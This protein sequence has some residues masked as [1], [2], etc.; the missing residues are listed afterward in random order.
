MRNISW[1]AFVMR[2]ALMAALTIY[3]YLQN[4]CLNNTTCIITTFNVTLKNFL[5]KTSKFVSSAFDPLAPVICNKHEVQT[6]NK[7]Q[8]G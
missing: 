5:V 1:Q 7:I 8:N 4:Q 6:T 2:T 3:M